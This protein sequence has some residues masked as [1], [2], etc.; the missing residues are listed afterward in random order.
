[1]T[2]SAQSNGLVK[3]ADLSREDIQELRGILRDKEK[4]T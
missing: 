4:R 2:E 3:R 1:M